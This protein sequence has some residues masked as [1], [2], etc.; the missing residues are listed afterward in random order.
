MG[1]DPFHPQQF[2]KHD[3]N[4]LYP[5]S[6]WLWLITGTINP[7][8]ITENFP[9]F[10]VLCKCDPLSRFWLRLIQLQLSLKL[11]C[12]LLI[13][14]KLPKIFNHVFTI[15]PDE[16]IEDNSMCMVLLHKF[17]LFLEIMTDTNQN[18]IST[19]DHIKTRL[20]TNLRK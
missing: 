10:C 17:L 11:F 4:R 9:V 19:I 12:H 2:P 18:S 16:L 20:S 13:Y 5:F 1:C 7:T 14:F 3:Q 8:L 6:F 15:Y